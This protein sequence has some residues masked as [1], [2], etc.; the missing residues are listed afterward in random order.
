MKTAEEIIAYMELELALAHELYDEAKGVDPRKAM[1]HMVR[2]S[3]ITSLLE[4]IKG[5]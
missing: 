4:F 1:T 2:I 5:R 3:T